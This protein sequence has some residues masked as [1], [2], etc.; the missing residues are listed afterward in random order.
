MV[1]QSVVKGN[2]GPMKSGC[3]NTPYGKTRRL[4]RTLGEFYPAFL[5]RELTAGIIH[6]AV[7]WSGL[8]VIGSKKIKP[9]SATRV[10]PPLVTT[11]SGFEL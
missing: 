2:T 5:L 8:I 10:L 7:H 4:S 9:A 1:H 6:L 3:L 11:T